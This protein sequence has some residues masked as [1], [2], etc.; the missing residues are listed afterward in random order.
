MHSTIPRG[1]RVVPALQSTRLLEQLRE[2]IRY[3]H[4]SIRTEQVYVQW[5][6]SFIHFHGVRHPRE[7]GRDEV[8]AYLTH[9][10]VERRVAPSTHKQALSA[11]LFLYRHVLGGELPWMSELARPTAER[12]IP[13]VLT[14]PE[15]AAVL[16]HLQ[17]EPAL[18][19]RLLY[20]TG[21]RLL[22]GLRLR[23]KDVEF[24]RAVIVVRD[25]KGGKDRVVM[26]PR[27]LVEPMKAQLRR[28]RA[29]WA[30]DRAS[31]CLGV[32]L[33]HALDRKYPSA[34]QSWA[35]QWVFPA[36]E[37]SPDPRSDGQ[38]RRHHLSEQRLQRAMKQAVRQ[39]DIPKPATVHTLRHSFATHLLQSGT[40]I[41]TVQ[42]L[43]GHSD[44]ST[45]MIYTHVVKVSTGH[46]SSPLDV[47]ASLS[48][49][50]QPPLAP[51]GTA[52]RAGKPT[53]TADAVS[54]AAPPTPSPASTSSP[55]PSPDP[56]SDDGAASGAPETS[57][58]RSWWRRLGLW[59]SRRR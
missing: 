10:A 15:V 42:E 53:A 49:D 35:W 54:P 34:G 3:M 57:A 59:W 19:A 26:L 58:G 29:L 37:L 6:R 55:P 38:L 56:A 44:V 51:P 41:R 52:V 20:G 12:R 50:W 2:R 23:V 48:G 17:G 33:P 25:G 36:E 40:D 13:A 11:L 46:T 4:Y 21:M 8:V 31:G 27:S 32:H 47:L 43:L 16:A 18:L 9:L 28:S 7:M 30:Q 39:A 24:E 14:P 22:E 45:T 1:E 5:V